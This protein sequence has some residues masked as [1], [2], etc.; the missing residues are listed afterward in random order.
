M[1]VFS[2]EMLVK[3]EGAAVVEAALKRLKA[4]TTAVAEK[5][6]VTTAEVAKISAELKGHAAAV[7]GYAQTTRPIVDVNAQIANAVT[8]AKDA[9][10]KAAEEMAAAAAKSGRGV[11]NLGTQSEVSGSRAAKAAIGFAAVGQA[12]GRTGSLT[13]DAG[14]R[15]IEAGSQVA[16]M[17]GPKGLAVAAILS[18]ATFAMSKFR[19]TSTEAAEMAKKFEESLAQIAN[20][21]D[22][23]GIRQQMRDLELGV[24]AG[25][26]D[27]I[28]DIN[29]GLGA[30]RQRI[31]E[32]KATG[33][34]TFN[35]ANREELERL[36]EVL[37]TGEKN[38]ARLR[39]AM[40]APMPT[41][42]GAAPITISAAA[43][44]SGGSRRAA[45]LPFDVRFAAEARRA[46]ERLLAESTAFYRNKY[47]PSE[48]ELID[49]ATRAN[50]EKAKKARIESIARAGLDISKMRLAPVP[51]PKPLTDEQ[52]QAFESAMRIE[53]IKN[54][55]AVGIAGAVSGG[56]VS[57]LQAAI[58][59]GNI[60]DAF[61][62]M[63]QAIV[64]SLASVMVDVA[65]AAI[66]F[67]TLMAK[68]Q[69][70]MMAHPLL[71]VASAVA[72]LALARSMGGSAKTAPMSAIGGAGG[73]TYS[74][75]GGMSVPSSQII[76]GATSATT[77][78]GMQPRSS[79]NVTIIG[80]N[81][82]SAQRAMQELMAKANSRGRVG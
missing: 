54:N 58:A 52:I 61:Q 3:E 14:T 74:A 80:P 56:L 18:F 13:A 53:D 64:S 77:A 81:D 17:F 22:K 21:G 19:Q 48:Q 55:L 37:A 62:A 68:I 23:V 67:G 34:T 51:P 59:T 66:G 75:A 63:G 60:G 31:A 38:F 11:Q 32:L 24:P 29:D 33:F 27:S 65:L 73:L 50:A 6:K 76:F 12:I 16:M 5:M 41:T 42:G 1:Q 10:K 25:A 43:P 9:A 8:K 28:V 46:R 35:R 72:L 26:L 47:G 70:F 4:E 20:A 69:A 40:E 49:E 79:T 39:T 15:I 57:G 44:E 30:V 78:A 45:P 82:P 71:A 36:N 7:A 2:V